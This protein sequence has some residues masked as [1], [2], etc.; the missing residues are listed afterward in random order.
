MIAKYLQLCAKKA[1]RIKC[2]RALAKWSAHSIR[3][4]ASVSSS[5]AGKGS[6]FIQIRLR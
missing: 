6:P 5:E 4:G 1:Y 2:K 3:V